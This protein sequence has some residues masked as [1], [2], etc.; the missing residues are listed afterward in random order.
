MA[1]GVCNRPANAFPKSASCKQTGKDLAAELL[2]VM[3][4]SHGSLGKG[5]LKALGSLRTR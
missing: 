1:L 5:T 2:Q 3:P 4:T